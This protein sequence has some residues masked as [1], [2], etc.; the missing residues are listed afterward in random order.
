MWGALTNKNFVLVSYVPHLPPLFIF[1]DDDDED[2][3]DND[4]DDDDLQ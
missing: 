1:D 3:G 4:D 2:N